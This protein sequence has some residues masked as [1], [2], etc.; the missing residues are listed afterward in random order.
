[1]FRIS[2]VVIAT[3]ILPNRFVSRDYDRFLFFDFPLR[4]EPS[5]LDEIQGLAADGAKIQIFYAKSLELLTETDH[6]ESWSNAVSRI[7]ESLNRRGEMYGLVIADLDSGWLLA[8]HAP[9]EWGVF[10]FNSTSPSAQA[11]LSSVHCDDFLSTDDF[12]LA[13]HDANSKLHEYFDQKFINEIVE[14]Y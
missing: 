14:N 7:D 11:I 13:I 12:R 3:P 9:V 5:F 8:Q 10:A 1:M 2:S 6:C 4:N